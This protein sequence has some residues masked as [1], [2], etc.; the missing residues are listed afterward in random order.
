MHRINK[1]ILFVHLKASMHKLRKM[2]LTKMGRP[3]I[4]TCKD[5]EFTE[6][7]NWDILKMPYPLC[8]SI[9]TQQLITASTLA[10]SSL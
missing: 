6:V 1:C 9:L 3:V 8:Q 7:I 10:N 5:A 4:W 2:H